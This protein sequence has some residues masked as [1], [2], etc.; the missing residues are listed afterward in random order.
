M[1]KAVMI[2]IKSS[3]DCNHRLIASDCGVELIS[4]TIGNAC[5]YQCSWPYCWSWMKKCCAMNVIHFKE[6]AEE[7]L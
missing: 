1:P 2:S 7:L 6:V 5:T 3:T 4:K